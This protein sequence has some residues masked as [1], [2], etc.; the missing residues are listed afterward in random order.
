ML[1][2]RYPACK[3]QMCPLHLSCSRTPT[4]VE[5][6]PFSKETDPVD[7][8]FVADHPTSREMLINKPFLGPEKDIIKKVLGSVSEDLTYAYTYLIRGWPVDKNTIHPKFKDQS[9]TVCSEFD[10]KR[11]K[12]LAW[13]KHPEAKEISDRCEKFILSDIEKYRPKLLVLMGKTVKEILIPTE[14]KPITRLYD[15][16]RT[17]KGIT[18]RFISTPRSL[19]QNP[20]GKKQWEHQLKAIATNTVAKKDTEPGEDFLITDIDDALDYIEMIKHS[21]V[22]ISVDLETL[23]LNKRY[24]NKIATIQFTDN[25][26]GGVTIPLHHA[27]TPF[28][29]DEQERLI[30]ALYD[31]F[32]NP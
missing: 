25:I 4:V 24:G 28:T 31:L 8:L 18:T 17:F 29:P 5:R 1:E 9:L 20:S 32:H 11:T 7:I 13:A 14:P 15:S 22:P 19:I 30:A 6:S 23:N 26:N 10:L 2:T 3:T 27:E 21:E 12:T 16:F